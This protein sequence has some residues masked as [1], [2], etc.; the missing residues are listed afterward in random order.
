MKQ[1]NGLKNTTIKLTSSSKPTH[2]SKH[3]CNS[4]K[5]HTQ[6]KIAKAPACFPSL[7]YSAEKQNQVSAK[8]ENQAVFSFS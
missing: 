7:F 2:K 8:I 1:I 6:Q 3:I 5:A 4:H